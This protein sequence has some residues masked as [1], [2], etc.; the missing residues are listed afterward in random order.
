MITTIGATKLSKK[1][2]KLVTNVV[3]VYPLTVILMIIKWVV[4]GAKRL[5]NTNSNSNNANNKKINN[6]TNKNAPVLQDKKTI[7]IY[8]FFLTIIIA[9]ICSAVA[10]NN[11]EQSGN[12]KDKYQQFGFDEV[13]GGYLMRK[14]YKFMN[15]NYEGEL[16]IPET[17]NNKPVVE[18]DS[19]DDAFG[20][21]ITKIIGSKNLISIKV[22]AF[23]SRDSYA[24]PN[25]TEVIFPPDGKLKIV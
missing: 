18:I 2:W 14:S 7:L 5:T 15:P 3:F 23:G 10:T 11:S 21:G 4:S 19:I 1:D 13:D 24:M 8:V 17:Y 6:Y 20:R 9:I 12:D 16:V 25:L 22:A